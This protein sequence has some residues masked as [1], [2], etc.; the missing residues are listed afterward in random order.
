MIMPKTWQEDLELWVIEALS[1]LDLNFRQKK[2]QK[3]VTAR[4]SF[5]GPILTEKWILMILE[6]WVL[7][8]KE[9]LVK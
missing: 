2:T 9:L 4:L 1:M 5:K 3:E 6:F 8:A 7:L